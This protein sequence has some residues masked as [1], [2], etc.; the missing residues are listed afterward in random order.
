[1]ESM[2]VFGFRNGDM[3][4]V[5]AAQNQE[6][7]AEIAFMMIDETHGPFQLMNF[8]DIEWGQQVMQGHNPTRH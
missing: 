3:P 8:C 1:M 5:V 7:A 4:I 2:F 6:D